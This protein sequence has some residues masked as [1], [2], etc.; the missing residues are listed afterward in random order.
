VVNHSVG[1]FH[2]EPDGALTI[3]Q[4][5]QLGANYQGYAPQAL[6]LSPEGTTVFVNC[7]QGDGILSIPVDPD[8]G[9]LAGFTLEA[10]L[11]GHGRGLA[12]TDDG[13]FLFATIAG[14]NAV[15]GF[16][17]QGSN[18]IPLEPPSVPLPNDG[19]WLFTKGSLLVLGG[20]ETRMIAVYQIGAGGHLTPAPGSPHQTGIDFLTIYAAFDSGSKVF[21][22]GM[23]LRYAFGISPQGILTPIPG[24]PLWV[25]SE[26]FFGVSVSPE[27]IGDAYALAF[28]GFPHRGDPF[29]RIQGEPNTPFAL[30]VGDTC[31]PGLITDAAG[32][33]A[34]SAPPLPGTT[35]R[36]K[37][38]CPD[39]T[40]IREAVISGSQ[41]VPTLSTWSL[42]AFTFLLAL[43][44][45]AHRR[46]HPLASRKGGLIG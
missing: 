22:G 32:R 8:T 13:Q 14:G 10:S 6:V 31:T 28:V 1:V 17:I 44:A 30:Q 41:N 40:V 7:Y 12:L 20:M 19:I 16:R 2:I 26:A 45:L 11:P 15:Y 34:V 18:L 24:S 37:A 36:I 46:R 5:L 3:L 35:I 25:G 23:N 42:L 33:I 4:F 21:F 43:L 9:T 27:R 39:E 38:Y 29:I